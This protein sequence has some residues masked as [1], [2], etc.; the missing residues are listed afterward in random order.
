M[1]GILPNG[2]FKALLAY[3]QN[4][5][6][7]AELL[8]PDNPDTIPGEK[9]IR[10][11]GRKFDLVILKFASGS[12]A[13]QK[14]L[15]ADSPKTKNIALTNVNFNYIIKGFGRLNENNLKAQV[16]MKTEGFLSKRVLDMHWEGGRL[17][18]QLN[19]D[20]NLKDM[21]MG[22]RFLPLK[23]EP[24]PKNNCIRVINEKGIRIIMRSW[25][26]EQ[27]RVEELPQIE[28]LNVLDKIAD[29]TH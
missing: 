4:A 15:S 9:A 16:K 13:P 3:Y 23:V 10:I 2:V 28:I 29:Y 20:I 25:D 1:V 18:D 26:D 17:A 21:I 7:N 12:I 14:G 8:E 5:G 6:L 27:T 11:S 24:D 22:L 19:S